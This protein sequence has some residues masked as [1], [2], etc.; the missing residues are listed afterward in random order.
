[1]PPLARTGPRYQGVHTRMAKFTFIKHDGSTHELPLVD[2]SSLMQ[3]ARDHNI[4]GIDGDCGG[5]A[6]C[7][8]CHVI[9]DHA[10]IAKLKPCSAEEQQMLAMI[11]DLQPG[12]RL[13]C[14]IQASPQL[15]GLTLR[16]PEY[17]M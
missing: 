6:A 7:G 8:T 11:P 15:D 14:Q 1:M 5:C 10:W 3:L 12:S 2:D 17:Q 4:A 9:V 13:A 16:I